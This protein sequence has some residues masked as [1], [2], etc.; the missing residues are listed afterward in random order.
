VRAGMVEDAV[1]LV[2][3][4][5]FQGVQW[6]YEICPDGDPWLLLLLAETRAALP[7][8]ALLSV[9]TP[10][11][12]PRPIGSW[13]WSSAYFERVARLCDLVAVMGYDT[14]MYLPRAYVG[15][16]GQQVIHVSRAAWNA[17]P[18]CRVLIGVPTYSAGGP[19]HHPWSENL[20]VALKGVRRG[21]ANSGTIA[22]AVAGVA[23]F[24]DYTTQRDEWR[25]YRSLWLE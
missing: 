11:W 17:N 23:L 9:A 18:E 21:L 16:I 14:G 25:T 8:S 3:D 1:W 10:V 24:A 19:S 20:S 6:D 4:C 2:R 15:L 7:K 12:V 13:G 5:G 22:S